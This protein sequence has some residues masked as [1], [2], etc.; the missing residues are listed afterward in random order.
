MI[1]TAISLALFLLNTKTKEA[2][3]VTGYTI[4]EACDLARERK[5][6]E[7]LWQIVAN[8]EDEPNVHGVAS[9]VLQRQR[10]ECKP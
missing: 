10:V 6:G 1:E 8:L 4:E 9:V 5:Q 7:Q 2:I 3:K